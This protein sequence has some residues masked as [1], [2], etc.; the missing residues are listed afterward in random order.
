MKLRQ[1]PPA[2]TLCRASAGI[3]GVHSRIQGVG[4]GLIMLCEHARPAVPFSLNLASFVPNL[5]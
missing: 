1:L 4:V 5:L 3:G 2:V